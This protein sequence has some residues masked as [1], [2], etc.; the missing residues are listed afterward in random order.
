MENNFHFN[1]VTNSFIGQIEVLNKRIELEIKTK[2]S[3]L[4]WTEIEN[5]VASLKDTLLPQIIDTSS[6]LLLEFVR[7]V[8]FGVSEPF[9][10][11]DFRL[12]AIVYYGKV[13]NHVFSVLVDDFELI[14]KRYHSNYAE[15]DDPYG[16]YIIRVDNR[17]I[18][19]VRREQI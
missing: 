3:D 5:F 2:K 17:L 1:E 8:P 12:E 4:N 11:Y 19:G 10:A 13:D 7:L 18:T 6:K 9:D 14:F 15:S 16:N